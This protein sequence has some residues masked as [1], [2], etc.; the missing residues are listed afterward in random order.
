MATY[1]ELN[2]LREDSD[3]QDKLAVACVKKAQSLIDAGSLTTN[4]KDWANS[5]L[6]NPRA[7]GLKI[8]N[9]VL[10]A[11]SD[12]TVSQIQSATDS[13]IQTNV[14]AAVDALIA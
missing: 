5:V 7:E 2:T 8:I 13:T 6:A 11:N 3:L 14:D 9:Y 4:A 1:L 12:S 10:A